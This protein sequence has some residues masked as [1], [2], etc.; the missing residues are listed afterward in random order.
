[1]KT[2]FE[3]GSFQYGDGFIRSVGRY[4]EVDTGW[5]AE[6]ILASTQKS[7][8]TP[9]EA[10]MLAKMDIDTA[11]RRAQMSGGKLTVDHVLASMGYGRVEQKD[12]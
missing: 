10:A 1:M 7:Y 9:Q 11:L 12:A 8:K 2:K 4:I 5:Q 6:M 3:A